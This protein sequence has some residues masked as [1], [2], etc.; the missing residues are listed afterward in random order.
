MRYPFLAPLSDF[1]FVLAVGRLGKP[2]ID[3]SLYDRVV[4]QSECA[5]GIDAIKTWPQSVGKW[6]CSRVKQKM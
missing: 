5:K 6:D 3:T 2:E 1:Q 4:R